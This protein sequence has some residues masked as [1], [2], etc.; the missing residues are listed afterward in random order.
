MKIKVD[1]NIPLRLVAALR[2]VGHDVQTV[3]EE[4]LTSRPDAEIWAAAC[5]EGRFLITQD[6]DFSDIRLLRPGTHPGLLVVRL[7][8][9]GAVALAARVNA[10]LRATSI[11]SLAGCLS[12][13]TDRKLRIKRA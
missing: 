13:L 9:P 3:A 2:D 1:E 8:E 12:V 6:L 11:E 7:R 5:R 4:G 10:A